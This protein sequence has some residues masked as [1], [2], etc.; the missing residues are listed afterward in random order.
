MKIALDKKAITLE[1][2]KE[3]RELQQSYGDALDNQIIEN[4]A[5]RASGQYGKL[6]KVEKIEVTKNHYKLTIWATVILEDFDK[7]IKT[8]FDVLQADHF[9]LDHY[10]NCT[11]IYKIV[12]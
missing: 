7:F 2:A 6:V 11:R 12:D 9:D 8:S 10:D 1:E 4:M 5:C 3:A